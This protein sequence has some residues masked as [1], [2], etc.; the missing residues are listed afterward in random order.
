MATEHVGELLSGYLDGELT[1]QQ[2]QRVTLHCSGCEQCRD[3]L[4]ELRALRERISGAPLSE[5]GEDQW[6]ENMND[7]TVQL[8][9]GIGW[10]LLEAGVTIATGTDISGELLVAIEDSDKALKLALYFGGGVALLAAVGDGA[11]RSIESA[12]Q[13]TIQV[14][15]QTPPDRKAVKNYDRLFPI[16]RQLYGQLKDSMSALAELQQA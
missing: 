6:R 1:Q 4:A 14:A 15:D 8:S 3:D 13:A 12:C 16:Y 10:L 11:Y 2:R 9:R 7:T 5:L